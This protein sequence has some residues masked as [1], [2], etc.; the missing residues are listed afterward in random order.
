MF[1]YFLSLR[2]LGPWWYS[3]VMLHKLKVIKGRATQGM[4]V[5]A[6]IFYF[7]LYIFQLY[8]CRI[9]QQQR[10]FWEYFCSLTCRNFFWSVHRMIYFCF[11][12]ERFPIKF[13]FTTSPM[14]LT[15]RRA[16]CCEICDQL[17]HYRIDSHP[18]RKIARKKCAEN[19]QVTYRPINNLIKDNLTESNRQLRNNS[20][21]DQLPQMNPRTNTWRCV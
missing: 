13:E 10:F 4:K 14:L 15:F 1:K 18:T 19:S 3:F 7:F 8:L 5:I 6:S 17:R 2:S 12:V 11:V 20:G 16:S 9:S 21:I